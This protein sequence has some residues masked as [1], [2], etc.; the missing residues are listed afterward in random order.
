MDNTVK[1][2]KKSFLFG[3]A[4]L[5]I[6][7][8][9]REIEYKNFIWVRFLWITYC[10]VL[11]TKYLYDEIP[12]T[13]SFLRDMLVKWLIFGFRALIRKPEIHSPQEDQSYIFYVFRRNF[14]VFVFDYYVED[15]RPDLETCESKYK[16]YFRIRVLGKTYSWSMQTMYHHIDQP[17][18]EKWGKLALE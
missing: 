3:L 11:R 6:R 2:F 5:I 16:H 18:I 4:E 8:E 7:I 10:F 15:R 1:Y 14:W 9:D 12:Y 17:F 13:N